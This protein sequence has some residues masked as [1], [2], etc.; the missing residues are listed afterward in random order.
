M[1]LCNTGELFTKTKKKNTELKKIGYSRYNYR[2]KLDNAYF[3]HGMAY[4]DFQDLARR[5]TCERVL[6]GEAFNIEN[7]I[8][9]N[10]YQRKLTSMI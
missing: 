7:Y 8:Q 10:G 4:G 6:P 9:C 5:T 2:N 3:Q 1:H